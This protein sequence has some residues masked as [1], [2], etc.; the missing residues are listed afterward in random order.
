MSVL[1]QNTYKK[2]YPNSYEA[3]ASEENNLS[4]EILDYERQ[5]LFT[6]VGVKPAQNNIYKCEFSDLIDN[7]SKLPKARVLLGG[8]VL[9]LNRNN[10]IHGVSKTVSIS[11]IFEKC[12]AQWKQETRVSSSMHQIV[13]NKAYQRIIG[14]GM[15]ALPFIFVEY[16][17]N[18][19]HWHNALEAIT[20]ENPVLEDSIGRAGKIRDAW[21]NWAKE[22]GYL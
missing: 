3:W 11:K 9:I 21:I 16:Q 12:L 1:N 14:L 2:Y 7:L 8:D 17:N 6:Y 15:D 22:K 4:E 19:G 10:V 20:G 18:G 13:L 5:D